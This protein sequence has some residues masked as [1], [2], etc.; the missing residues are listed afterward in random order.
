LRLTGLPVRDLCVIRIFVVVA[1]L[2][3]IHQRG[4]PPP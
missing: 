2:H 3:S 1:H 4:E